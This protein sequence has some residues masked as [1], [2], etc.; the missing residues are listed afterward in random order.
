MFSFG[1]STDYNLNEKKFHKECDND[2]QS[3]PTKTI[4][5]LT[6]KSDLLLLQ[7]NVLFECNLSR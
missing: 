6:I 4:I 3:I 2:H 1:R 7:Q 5:F